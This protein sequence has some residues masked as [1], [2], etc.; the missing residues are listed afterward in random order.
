M[1]SSGL[2][3]SR[4]ARR[5]GAEVVYNEWR[6]LTITTL[7]TIATIIGSGIL[8]LP[9]TMY[10]TS[11]SL[12]L[13]IFTA[14]FLAQ[15]GVI[16]ASIE[17]FQAGRH[18]RY[19]YQDTTNEASNLN[20]KGPRQSSSQGGTSW[21]V[22]PT[23]AT[24]LNPQPVLQP[25][26]ESTHDVSLF[27]LADNYLPNRILRFIFHV[28][29]PLSFIGLLVSYGLAGPQAL[30]QVTD[31]SSSPS[32]PPLVL[33][34]L[35]SFLGVLM[36]VFFVNVLLPMFSSLTVVKGGLFIAVV[37]IVAALP[38]STHVS[39]I[40]SL[41]RDPIDWSSSAVPFLMC[42]VALGG[43]SNTLAVTFRLLPKHPTVSQTS[44]FRSATLLGLFI[45][46]VLNIGWVM[47]ILQVVPRDAPSN[48]PSLTYAYTHGQISTIPLIATL[49]THAYIS[50]HLLNIVSIFVNS[51]IL[52]STI[53]SFFVMAAGCKSYIDGAVI[54]AYKSLISRGFL[55]IKRVVL[56]G[57]AYTLTF[58]PTI[59]A[60]VWNP[61]G[62]ITVLTQFTSL[63][64]NLQ[65]GVLVFVMLYYCRQ[66]AS[67]NTLD[68]RND[69]VDES[70]SRTGAERK[71]IPLRLSSKVS[72]TLIIYCGIIFTSACML[73]LVGR[74][75]GI[76]L[77][78]PRE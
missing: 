56:H 7:T 74:F 38:R 29:T 20:S 21:A 43:L 9:V 73:V 53:V 59:L 75:F 30:W 41:F 32:T 17:I 4:Y 46:Y 60:I 15:M 33:F 22:N 12:F 76:E 6:V 8:A 16:F 54:A 50:D 67:E 14:S 47:A 24:P 34:F 72:F 57:L 62:F 5:Q 64:L 44:R 77:D 37:V 2:S 71:D 27:E 58:G 23:E 10:H 70:A 42:T 65:G 48:Q 45:C 39:S 11:L 61:D 19:P 49:S 68:D 28:T 18:K 25:D 1:P 63:T 40:G 51:F 26:I 78:A 66:Q 36:V 52:V 55:S 3:A 35:Y 13:I 31:P 69:L